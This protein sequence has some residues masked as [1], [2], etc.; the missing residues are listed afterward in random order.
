M[1]QQPQRAAQQRPWADVIAD[2][3][4]NNLD[5]NQKKLE[6]C[7]GNLTLSGLKEFL[8]PISLRFQISPNF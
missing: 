3:M 5:S 7:I 1:Q 2:V 8:F 6:V 4:R